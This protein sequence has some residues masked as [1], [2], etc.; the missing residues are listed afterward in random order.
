MEPM[1]LGVT[2][3][4][5]I[6]VMMALGI[7]VATSMGIVAI[8]GMVFSVGLPY[9]MSNIGS[10]PYAITSQFAFAVVPMFVLMGT[11]T[12]AT[13]ISSELYLAAHKWTSRLHGSLYYATVLAAGAFGAING[14]SM[15]SSA[16]F[17]RISL[18]EMLKFGYDKR[19]SAGCIAAAGTFASMIPPSIGMVLYAI[20]AEMSVGRL[21]IA[22]IMPGLLTVV[23]YLIGIR[24]MIFFRPELAPVS[25]ERFSFPEKLSTLKGLWATVVL[26]VIVMGGIYTGLV[27][28]STAGAA[29]AAGALIIGLIRLRLGAE[30]FWESL[31]QAAITSGTLFAVIVAGVFLS[32]LLLVSGFVDATITIVE[33]LGIGKYQLLA[34]VVGMYL[35]L[36]CF[37]DT[38]SLMIMTVPFLYPIAQSVGIDLIWFGVIIIKLT[39]IA[40]ITPPVGLNLFAVLGASDRQI[41]SFELFS[42]V[43]PFILLEG[44][45]LGLL[46]A[47][48][49]VV[50]W[51]PN[52]MMAGQ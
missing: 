41:S 25:A 16:I 39:E 29:G 11:L 8:G 4:A 32:R 26:V 1:I 12:T 43:A 14:S 9:A 17:T 36:G 47:F 42:G 15:V 2:I 50:L 52:T 44:L 38:V 20:L 31:K 35:I 40:A 51:L 22:G 33:D 7:H 19:V 18:P 48:P 5:I 10:L 27:Y 49:Q 45:V 23:V 28:P 46:I 24:L 30:R 37:I 34:G 3:F 13:G 6:L 21:L